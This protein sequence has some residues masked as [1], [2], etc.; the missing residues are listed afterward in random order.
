MAGAGSAGFGA[1]AGSAGAAAGGVVGV[2]AGGVVLCV[3]V[4]S[5]LSLHAAMPSKAAAQIEPRTSFLMLSL[6]W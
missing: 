6:L 2:S 5:V 3:V 4:L 1:G